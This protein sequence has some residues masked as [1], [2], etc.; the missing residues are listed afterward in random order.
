MLSELDV[1]VLILLESSRSLS[2]GSGPFIYVSE[3]HKICASPS[4]THV[5]SVTHKPQKTK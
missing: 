4:M 2:D 1:S 5:I 3:K